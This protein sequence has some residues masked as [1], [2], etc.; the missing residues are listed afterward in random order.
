MT[1]LPTIFQNFA[2]EWSLERRMH[3]LDGAQKGHA[4]GTAIFKSDGNDDTWHY[5]EQGLGV[6]YPGTTGHP[7]FRT[8][9]Y[10]LNGE[11]ID[12]YPRHGEQRG[13]L[14]QSYRWSQKDK[15]L[16]PI[17]THHCALDQYRGLYEIIDHHHFRLTT[18]VDGPR[19]GY[20]IKTLFS[21]KQHIIE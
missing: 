8:Y 11:Q 9:H 4:S 3:A 10:Q 17:E 1:A 5:H 14:Y 13:A 18:R 20:V 15:T 16:Y 21:R 2:G 19:K 12:V 7:F 6:H